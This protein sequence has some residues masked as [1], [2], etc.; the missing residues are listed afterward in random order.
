[1][2]YSKKAL[3]N[4]L[5]II[6]IP[7]PAVKS[8]TVLILFGVGSRYE[9]RR[10]SGI[11]H[12]LEHMAFKGS[13]NYP[14]ALDISS[15]IDGIGGEFNAFTGKEYTGYYVKAA[16]EHL[17]IIVD[18]LSDMI[19]NSKFDPGEI[20]RERGVILE[21][22]RMY[23]DTPVRY[24]SS[25][26]E[27]L[28]FGDNPLG[29]DTIGFEESLNGLRREDFAT[30]IQRF[31]SP[32]NLVV[33]VAGEVKNSQTLVEDY[34]SS[35]RKRETPLFKKVIE[36]KR[37][38]VKLLGKKT[39]Q[40]HFCIGFYSYK[41]GHSRRYALALLNNILGGKM[42]S[43][44]FVS[45]RERRGLAYYV[46]SNVEEYHDSGLF[47][48]QAGTEPRKAQEAIKICL[49]EFSKLATKQVDS[50]ELKKAKE[51]LKG[52]LVLDLEDSREVATIF[53]A[54]EV[55][56][57]KVRTP[58]EIMRG[59]DK[60]TEEEVLGVAGDLVKK[61]SLNLAMIGPFKEEDKFL[62]LL[63]L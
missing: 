18:V 61:E 38:K 12:F 3:K 48:A 29:W 50:V 4:S 33:G 59:I 40:A 2:N 24:I 23:Q 45:L 26:F 43:R 56:E 28:S 57:G 55:L 54:G 13:K 1:M 51:N 8:V 22:M 49:E 34:L 21:E 10:I 30:F 63:K 53:A 19:L 46:R 58:D 62:K 6:S 11:S 47:F 7:I 35:M 60:V 15:T 31:Y 44:L 16:S 20:E 27:N 14:T 41:V 39:E 17:K 37:P 32:A 42:S 36:I 5:R 9:E 52:K 25:L